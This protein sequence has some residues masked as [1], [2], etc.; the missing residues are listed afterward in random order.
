M[1]TTILIVLATA[2]V[3]VA[4]VLTGAHNSSKVAADVAT[5]KADLAVARADAA[6]AKSLAQKLTAKL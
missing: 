5:L 2:I 6:A 3:F 4:G 1:I